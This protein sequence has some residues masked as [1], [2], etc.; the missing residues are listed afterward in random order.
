MKLSELKQAVDETLSQFPHWGRH[1][2]V[3][4]VSGE[5]GIGGTPCAGVVGAAGGMDWDHGKF[6]LHPEA[7]LYRRP[8]KLKEKK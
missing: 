5:G 1:E 6:M 3:I 7:P 2:V 4:P 8:R